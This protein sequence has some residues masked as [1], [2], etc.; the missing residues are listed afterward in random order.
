MPKITTLELEVV[1]KTRAQTSAL[2]ELANGLRE[3]YDASQGASEAAKGIKEEA[4]ALKALPT[5]S[6]SKASGISAV[7]KALTEVAASAQ[8]ISSSAP[9]DMKRVADAVAHVATVTRDA[10]KTAAGINRQA[11]ALSTMANT[12]TQIGDAGDRIAGLAISIG[13][14]TNAS[15]NGAASAANLASQARSLAKVS[16]SVAGLRYAGAN[17]GAFADSL[18]K[19]NALLDGKEN[20]TEMLAKQVS[21]L[22]G[23]SRALKTISESAEGLHT[24]HQQIDTLADA[25]ETLLNVSSKSA[26]STTLFE[27]QA[28]AL[29]YV[30]RAMS[31]LAN[32]SD[33]L[34]VA[35]GNIGLLSD[36]IAGLF[37]VIDG[38]EY[39]V[40]VFNV[41]ADAISK[42][43]RAGVA[44]GDAEAAIKKYKAAIDGA[45]KSSKEEQV[46]EQ[47]SVSIWRM[48]GASIREAASSAGA[49]AADRLT[50]PF[51]HTTS[52]IDKATAALRRFIGQL[53][54][55]AISVAMVP[56]RALGGA[57]TSVVAKFK[58][59]LRS[60][61][62]IAMY[63]GLRSALRAITQGFKTGI[64]N[65]YKWSDLVGNDFKA[66]MDRIATS[67]NYLKNSLGAMA[68]PIIDMLAPVID[69][70]VDKFVSLINIVNQFFSAIAGKDTYRRAKKVAV[71]WGEQTDKNAAK[72]A[73]LNRQLMA[74]DE[75]NNITTNQPSGGS[76]NKAS[77]VG[78]DWFEV[79]K[80]TEG[81]TSVWDNLKQMLAAD[82][83][84]GI[85]NLFAD[86]LNGIVE[87]FDAS[88]WGQKIADK[89]N[90]GFKFFK[91]LVDEDSGGIKWGNL[92]IKA[93]K[94]LNALFGNIDYETIKDTVV[95]LVNG[96]LD[97]VKNFFVT[98]EWGQY[99]LDATKLINGLF[100]NVT[101]EKIGSTVSSIING[102]FEF[103][104]TAVAGG[105][106][107]RVD[108]VTGEVFKEWQGG[109]D[110]KGI[111]ESIGTAI[112]EA[113][114]SIDFTQIGKT[115]A[116]IGSGLLSIITNAIS[117]IDVGDIFN[118]IGDLISGFFSDPSKAWDTIKLAGL[119]GGLKLLFG[120]AIPA[121]ITGLGSLVSGAFTS[122]FS[123]S[124]VSGAISSG[125]KTAVEAGVTGASI[126]STAFGGLLSNL[127]PAFV[128]FMGTWGLPILGTV[129]ITAGVLAIV[130]AREWDKQNDEDFERSKADP[131]YGKSVAGML[132]D[133]ISA[134][135][136]VLAGDSSYLFEMNQLPS[137][138]S[139]ATRGEVMLDTV[140]DI[141]DV[142]RAL[143]KAQEYLKHYTP[144][145]NLPTSSTPTT[146]QNT[147]GAR[148]DPTT[149]EWFVPE[150]DTTQQVKAIK[151][152]ETAAKNAR[153][154]VKQIPPSEDE[155]SI[156]TTRLKKERTSVDGVKTAANNAG[157]A[158]DGVAPTSKQTNAFKD[159]ATVWGKAV[160]GIKTAAAKAGAELNG[161]KPTAKE[162][163]AFQDSTSIWAKAV[164]GI[165]SAASNTNKEMD[166]VAKKRSATVSFTTE[167]YVKTKEKV[168]TVQKMLDAL[169]GKTYSTKLK[170]TVEALNGGTSGQQLVVHNY[171]G[172]GLTAYAEG[173]YPKMGDL[174]IA[175]EAGPELVGTINGKT[176]VSSNQEITGIA[177]AVYDTGEEEATLLR[178][179]NQLLRQ[180]LAK[181][182]NISL[183]P[184]VAAGRWVAQ[185]SNAYRKATGG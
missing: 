66:S 72:Q 95:G 58:N 153:S 111:G 38:Q 93:A 115:L 125:V 88:G 118:A 89:V 9:D 103:I 42:M 74:F 109:L 16:E 77:D 123:G 19:M 62:R 64:E 150:I 120:N 184:N 121:A 164:N 138:L 145:G 59:L 79:A 141:S 117:Q 83:W 116:D 71:E 8:G 48:L 70:L 87:N 82:D 15:E 26:E 169:S 28:R 80:I 162:N 35:Q 65:L 92:G 167:D 131:S 51:K 128:S 144:G 94:F 32:V 105:W 127:G 7:A 154:K 1:Q 136:K 166:K 50:K 161:V 11:A 29:A 60:F 6:A 75:L 46:V 41:L 90:A 63:R 178:E 148:L 137:T 43:A 34:G 86:K 12:A 13:Q 40:A 124:E 17:V 147:P 171:W 185:A 68:S 159:T 108:P 151:A 98:A 158:I 84:L 129:G 152:V 132:Q 177:D 55:K 133:Y 33:G 37:S 180:L 69:V 140:E 122:L 135:N 85:G 27:R 73:K 10:G 143:A 53:R 5:V 102:G 30:A 107:K 174:F 47:K 99:A 49:L 170:M 39:N 160:N 126:S 182:T 149:G 172:S 36:K 76:G 21:S 57:V 175:N 157:K 67:L 176:A 139:A 91:G 14:L 100:N 25:M 52:T 23:A 156:F 110:F 104:K 2:K 20:T 44:L 113:L 165:K 45:Q 119:I 114:T 78:D 106:K 22:S 179:Q 81:F 112:S 134:G 101:A 146:G 18:K 168:D 3:L 183:A 61:K 181:N 130:T 56:M 96:G 142:S 31:A 54:G 24:A 163:K 4:D 173:G 97:L 155:V